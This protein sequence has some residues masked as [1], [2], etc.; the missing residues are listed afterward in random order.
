MLRVVGAGLRRRS[1]RTALLFAAIVL[2]ATVTAAHSSVAHDHM[3]DTVAM[4]EPSPAVPDLTRAA[5]ATSARG[6]PPL[7]V[8]LVALN[9][10]TGAFNLVAGIHPST[11]AARS[12][13]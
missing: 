3:G 4:D 12:A 13:A 7:L 5:T 8:G 1:R 10:L 6:D 2:S 9:V 11:T